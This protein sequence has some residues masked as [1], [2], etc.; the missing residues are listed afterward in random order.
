[1]FLLYCRWNF[2]DMGSLVPLE[3]CK[4][5]AL[6]RFQPNCSPVPSIIKTPIKWIS[7]FRRM[8]FITTGPET[9]RI[10][11]KLQSGLWW[12]KTI[13]CFYLNCMSCLCYYI[14]DVHE[15]KC[16]LIF[17]PS[18]ILSLLVRK[19]CSWNWV[20]IIV[21]PK[22]NTKT[23]LMQFFCNV[24]IYVNLSSLIKCIN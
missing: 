16:R 2:A 17:P 13:C 12:P 8:V 22:N 7:S 23:R 1:M 24:V 4:A 14:E 21:H 11:G 3:G 9:S 6:T 5:Y 20:K 19:P 15:R 18:Y 10:Y